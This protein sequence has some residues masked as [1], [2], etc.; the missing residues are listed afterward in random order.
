M[1]VRLRNG[2]PLPLRRLHLFLFVLA[3]LLFGSHAACA[4]ITVGPANLPGGTV[5]VPYNESFSGSGGTGPY[6]FAETGTL[7]PGL[8]L[9]G[10][11]GQLS[12]TP[13]TQGVYNFSI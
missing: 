8:S 3:F 11:S 2:N 6:T 5:G 9:D 1:C 12:G 4:A 13:T 7:P 10:T